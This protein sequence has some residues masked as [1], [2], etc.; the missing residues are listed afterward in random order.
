MKQDKEATAKT[1]RFAS[2][3]IT[4][5]ILGILAYS[6]TNITKLDENVYSLIHNYGESA[7]FL[8]SILLDLIPQLIS[9]VIAL[10]TGIIAGINV[11]YAI[12]ATIF[13]STLGSVIGFALG[14]KYMF[15]AVDILTSEKS[16]KRLNTLTNKY[17]KIIVPLAAISP[18]PYLP[19][20][21]GAINFSK[22][23]FLIYGIIP[24][25][26]SFIVYGYLI[27]AI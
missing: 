13:G 10:G 8:I 23:N 18:L 9:P 3:F 2:A 26:L 11:H 7:L 21:L 25:A 17:G 15:E 27:S 16:A 1:I 4:L 14:K 12:I 19:V 6:L 22:R 5:T 24:R 20:F